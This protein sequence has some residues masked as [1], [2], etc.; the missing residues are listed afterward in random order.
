MKSTSR[1]DTEEMITIA[2]CLDFSSQGKRGVGGA[3][4]MH[5]VG[6]EGAAPGVLV[7][8]HRERGDIGDENVE[9]SRAP[10]RSPRRSLRARACRRHRRSRRK[11]SRPW[12]AAP[13]RCPRLRPALARA[14]RD[15][16][17]FVGEN[18]GASPADALAAARD[19]GVQ[20]LKPRSIIRL[21]NAGGRKSLR[22]DAPSVYLGST[23]LPTRILPACVSR[24]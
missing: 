6:L 21:L 8:L 10:W 20:S 19:D 1:P 9:P 7:V 17:A 16:G 4:R 2:G 13:R 22:I 18:V 23:M 11:R 15:I 5:H 14:N 12:L 24:K 3:H